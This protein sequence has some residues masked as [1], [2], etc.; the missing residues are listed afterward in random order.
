MH[1]TYK[2]LD[3]ARRD[4]VIDSEK[5]TRIPEDIM[6]KKDQENSI[7]KKMDSID[8]DDKKC[9]MVNELLLCRKKE[10]SKMDTSSSHVEKITF[11]TKEFKEND[12]ETDSISKGFPQ[13]EKEAESEKTENFPE[14]T[15][16]QDEVLEKN[17]YLESIFENFQQEQP[18][19]LPPEFTFME[20]SDFVVYDDSIEKPVENKIDKISTSLKNKEIDSSKLTNCW[21]PDVEITKVKMSD[22]K[23]EPSDSPIF[24][25]YI[26]QKSGHLDE[27]AVRKYT[28]E[29]M[30]EYKTEFEPPS[31]STSYFSTYD[32]KVVDLHSVLIKE[33]ISLEIPIHDYHSNACLDSEINLNYDKEKRDDNQNKFE[34]TEEDSESP[35][36]SDD[37]RLQSIFI[38][39]LNSTYQYDGDKI[40]DEH[41]FP[42]IDNQSSCETSN[43]GNVIEIPTPLFNELENKDLDFA[44][45]ND[46]DLHLASLPQQD[47]SKVVG[48]KINEQDDQLNKTESEKG[49]SLLEL[50]DIVFSN[51]FP[52][53]GRNS[54]N[55]TTQKNETNVTPSSTVSLKSKTVQFFSRKGLAMYLSNRLKVVKVMDIF[56]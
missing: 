43:D 28:N 37:C 25:T 45:E 44:T 33:D 4:D 18:L 10:N 16:S 7:E 13:T 34:D 26:N 46:D 5:L 54:V 8:H 27:N 24:H 2:N 9:E 49:T 23:N 50:T 36:E 6:P 41:T 39:Q 1:F 14:L 55:P 42:I 38:S 48:E 51:S 53:D 56:F 29:I 17:R 19:M 40:Q 21:L 20:N 3:D 32:D 31:T 47:L 52:G 12:F 15:F 35:I 22:N 30:E 11:L